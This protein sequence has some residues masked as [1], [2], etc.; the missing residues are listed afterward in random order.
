M[1]KWIVKLVYEWMDEWTNERTNEQIRL[2]KGFS[3]K[4]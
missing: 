3:F 1:N 4:N 2:N